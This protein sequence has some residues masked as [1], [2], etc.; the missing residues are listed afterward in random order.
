[1]RAQK[2]N[3]AA[4]VST[5]KSRLS[6]EPMLCSVRRILV[7]F[8]KSRISCAV[9]IGNGAGHGYVDTDDTRFKKSRIP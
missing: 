2:V 5:V 6:L 7:D 3:K 8:K 9:V 4:V 1:M